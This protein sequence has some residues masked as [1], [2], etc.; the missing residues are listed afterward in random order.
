[1]KRRMAFLILC[2]ALVASCAARP[3]EAP[4]EALNPIAASI[5]GLVRLY[6]EECVEQRHLDWVRAEA[7]RRRV[8]HCTNFWNQLVTPEGKVGDCEGEVGRFI[9]WSVLATD[10]SDIEITLDQLPDMPRSQSC[11]IVVPDSL[12]QTLREATLRIAQTDPAFAQ[13][14]QHHVTG[15]AGTIHESESWVWASSVR[16]SE[17]APQLGL[18]RYKSTRD[19]AYRWSLMRL[20]SGAIP[21]PRQRTDTP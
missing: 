12:G 8:Y 21:V 14:P 2:G 16:A 19:G 1:M 5:D 3:T 11:R 15:P 4:R 13:P 20:T 6:Q 18:V 9:S 10:N 7:R 17:A